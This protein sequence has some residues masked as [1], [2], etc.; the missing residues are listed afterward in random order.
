MYDIEGVDV[1]QLGLVG[2]QL[3][4]P[5]VTAFPKVGYVFRHVNTVEQFQQR[6]HD[7]WRVAVNLCKWA[8][9]M[10]C[11][12]RSVLYSIYMMGF[13][14]SRHWALL[15]HTVDWIDRCLLPGV[16][17][18]SDWVAWLEPV[19]YT[20][21]D[22]KPG[23]KDWETSRCENSVVWTPSCSSLLTELEK[24]Q[25]RFTKRLLY[26]VWVIAVT[27]IDS[28]RYHCVHWKV[29]DWQLI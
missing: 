4:M 18:N 25:R 23:F 24:V 13:Q 14:W 8:A 1:A 28:K 20:V 11:L 17:D 22:R 3:E 9:A 10:W 6:M 15:N 26:L 12:I 16:E 27:V 2:V 19:E 21:A 29:Q 7:G 5:R